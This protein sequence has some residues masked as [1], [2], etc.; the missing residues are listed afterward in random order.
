[1]IDRE[2]AA[3]RIAAIEARAAGRPLLAAPE[4]LIYALR[5][6]NPDLHALVYEMDAAPA[7][8][9]A[10]YM[11]MVEAETFAERNPV[12]D[13]RIELDDLV[14]AR[15]AIAQELRQTV[16]TAQEAN[17]AISESELSRLDELDAR[18][19]RL[20]AE[21]QRLRMTMRKLEPYN[22]QRGRIH[23][24]MNTPEGQDGP[25]DPIRQMLKD[26]V[27]FRDFAPATSMQTRGLPDL[28]WNAPPGRLD[29]WMGTGSADVAVQRAISDFANGPALFMNDFAARVAVY[30]RAMSPWLRL[31]T[32][33][34]ADNGR[35]VVLPMLT[36]DS[37]VY[38]PGEG[39]AITASDPTL[40][41]ATASPVSYKAMTYISYESYED[42]EVNLTD[43][44]ARSHARSI[45]LSFGSAATT[46]ILAAIN[47]G[48]T[49]TGL[50]GGS[51]ATF[52]G[53]E[54][55]IDL[56][57]GRA[58]PYRLTSSWVMAN[59]AIKKARKWTDKNGEYLW[60]GFLPGGQP[61]ALDGQ[62]VYEDPYLSNPGSAIKSVIY[63][64]VGAAVT[65]KASAL[66]VAISPDFAF[67]KDQLTI[68]S[69]Q[70]LG[71]AVPDP[72]G[73][74]FLVSANS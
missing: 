64:D 73:L 13:K 16:E 62:S 25:A 38:T 65:I 10:R 28:D 8:L 36:V 50:G 1:M 71:L 54:D 60:Q 34:N 14:Y 42:E 47:N 15:R 37:T 23:A 17:R 72:T 3:D 19:D 66:R 27:P 22:A 59:G 68:K 24:A 52:F 31:A 6:N 18:Y 9:Q 33:I 35:P 4:T 39:T 51:T 63:G 46:A 48:G 11:R 56:K 53:Y 12:K 69:V 45:A 44:V 21:E 41:Q 70:R 5:S 58:A 29:N 74:A 49:A 2:R 61:D 43:L 30:Q 40:G 57:Y 32:M 20:T 55:L 26:H 7:T 67:D